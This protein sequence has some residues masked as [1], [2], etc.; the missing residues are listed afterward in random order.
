MDGRAVDDPLPPEAKRALAMC[1]DAVVAGWGE[2]GSFL[3]VLERGREAPM[4]PREQARALDDVINKA[5]EQQAEL[6]P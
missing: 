1:D 2:D 6:L 5:L 3:L 4:T